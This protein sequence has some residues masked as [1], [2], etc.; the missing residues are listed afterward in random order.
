LS[1]AA[2][3]KHR[4]SWVGLL[5]PMALV[6][7]VF[8]ALGTW[9][10]ERKAWKEGLIA[11]LNERVTALPVHLPSAAAWPQLGRAANEYRRV[12]FDAQFENAK[13]ALVY[14]VPSAFRPDVSGAGFWL[15]TPARLADGNLVVV[16][17]G[18][19]PEGQRDPS[20]RAAGQI[21]GIVRITGIMRWPDAKHWFSPKGDPAH[22]LW[23]LRDPATIAADKGWGAVAPFYVEQE[24]PVPPGGVP[25]PGKIVVNLR[26]AHMQYALTWY[27]LA[28]VLVVAFAAFARSSMRSGREVQGGEFSAHR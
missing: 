8:V 2:A 25:L 3:V 27:G 10:I 7:A 21:S 16:D 17:R 6:F 13:E 5:V 11:E 9:Q 22:N 1:A 18:F 23:Y 28:L 4:R 12:S 20:T 15:F 19:V 24:A 26:N 14:A